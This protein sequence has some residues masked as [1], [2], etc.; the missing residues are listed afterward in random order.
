MLRLFSAEILFDLLSVA[1]R[2]P[3]LRSETI[4][5]REKPRGVGPGPVIE[6]FESTPCEGRPVAVVVTSERRAATAVH[7][8]VEGRGR[9]VN[10]G[11]P[12]T[13]LRVAE[14]VGRCGLAA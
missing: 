11:R 7:R 3:P 5:G 1:R 13:A 10:P 4:H 2:D 14:F 8:R 12:K 6:P 9:D